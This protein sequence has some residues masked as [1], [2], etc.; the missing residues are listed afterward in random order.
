MWILISY[1]QYWLLY[2]ASSN[3]E[4]ED[5]PHRKLIE[6]SNIYQATNDLITTLVSTF[7]SWYL[8][9]KLSL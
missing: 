5:D 6:Y 8:R 3:Y 9:Y 7:L 1:I 2:L 4:G